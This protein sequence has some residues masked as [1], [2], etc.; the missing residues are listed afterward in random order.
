MME[1]SSSGASGKLAKGLPAEPTEALM[2]H[3]SPPPTVPS[4]LSE[5]MSHGLNDLQ[6]ATAEVQIKMVW[7]SLLQL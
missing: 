2:I 1:A 6:V 7:G 5:W 4:L 3:T